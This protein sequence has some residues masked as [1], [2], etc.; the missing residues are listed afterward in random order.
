[1]IIAIDGAL[2]HGREL[3][4]DLGEVRLF[5]GKELKPDDLRDVNALIVRT[6]TPVNAALLE[7]SAVTFVGAASAGVDHVDQEYLANKGIHF[8]YAAGCNADA[9]SEYILTALYTVAARRNWTLA[10]KSLAV[11]GVGNVGSRVARKARALGMNVLLCDPPLREK[12]GDSQYQPFESVL[13]ADILTFHV[14]LVT[15]GDYPTWRMVN[16]EIFA[17]LSPRQFLINSSRGEIFD[18]RE[19][20]SA[21][22]EKRISGAI[23]DV[24]E[25]EPEIDYSLLRYADIGTPHIAGTTLDGKIKAV[26]MISEYLRRF[27]GVVSSPRADDF[28][29]AIKT[30]RPAAG[31]T[32][33]N[34]AASVLRQVCLI[35]EDDAG[36]RALENLPEKDRG[37]SFE[38][39]RTRHVLRPEFPHFLVELNA[40]QSDLAGVF[41]GMGFQNGLI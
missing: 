8:Y 39:L 38:Q 2:P 35:D 27:S 33:Q 9:V 19:L 5:A 18:N 6:V 14:P 31:T 28:Y 24:W 16:R 10:E 26:S 21:L 4:S 20:L 22:R 40:Q 29:P 34:A 36:L 15:T 11:V 3:F 17:G 25:G 32:R 41:Q 7:G 37:K 23:L 13:N 12:T 1:M 30:I